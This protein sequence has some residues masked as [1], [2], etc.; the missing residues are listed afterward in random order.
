MFT[1]KFGILDTESVDID[2]PR[3]EDFVTLK[4]HRHR[5][6]LSCKAGKFSN[7]SDSP[8]AFLS[9]QSSVQCCFNNAQFVWYNAL[10]S[11]LCFKAKLDYLVLSCQ[12]CSLGSFTLS[13]VRGPRGDSTLPP[14]FLCI[15]GLCIPKSNWKWLHGEPLNESGT[16]DAGIY[17]PRST[18]WFTTPLTRVPFYPESQAGPRVLCYCSLWKQR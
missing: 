7:E 11:I 2:K 16:A 6:V 18:L 12:V 3:F 5:F 1:G 4:L 10:L 15:Y 13:E 14:V 8:G 9:S 17:A